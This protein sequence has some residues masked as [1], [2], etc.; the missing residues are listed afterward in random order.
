[1]KQ[2]NKLKEIN[3]YNIG[4]TYGMIKDLQ[5]IIPTNCSI[6]FSSS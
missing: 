4:F 3:I 6:T 1:M 2:S 5:N